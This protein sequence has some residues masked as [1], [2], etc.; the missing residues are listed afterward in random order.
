[1]TD[2]KTKTKIFLM[3]IYDAIGIEVLPTEVQECLLSACDMSVFDCAECENELVSDGILVS[4]EYD[5]QTLYGLSERG[6][7]ILSV[8]RELVNK[9]ELDSIVRGALRHFEEIHTGRY[10]Y[11]EIQ[12]ADGGWFVILGL[13][14]GERV[15]METKLFFDNKPDAMEAL[16]N[17]KEKPE[18]IFSG[19][20][21][22]MTGR[23]NHLF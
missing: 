2:N 7:Q 16:S 11:S 20:K 13:K 1:M 19:L 4:V 6:E 23:I 22:L 5:G 17:C 18:N 21:T 15:I 10:Y 14:C 12:N 9:S 3:S 8:S